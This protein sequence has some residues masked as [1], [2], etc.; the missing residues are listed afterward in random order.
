MIFITRMDCFIKSVSGDL[1]G[2]VEYEYKFYPFA[3]VQRPLI[4]AENES[5]DIGYFYA[6][7]GMQPN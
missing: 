5:L 4:K 1:R 6:L 3:K 7:S 2:K